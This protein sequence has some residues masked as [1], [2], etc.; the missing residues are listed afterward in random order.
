MQRRNTVKSRAVRR[1]TPR[2]INVH[3]D[4]AAW[5]DTA[6]HVL[7]KRGIDGVRIEVLAKQ[8]EVTKGS[9]YWHFK[10]RAALLEEMLQE[11]RRRATLGIIE[12]L[13]R[14]DEAPLKRM[15]RL[16]RLQF[17]AKQAEFGADVELSVRLWGRHDASAA[18]VLR[19]I[20]ELRLRYISK[21]MVGIGKTESEARARAVLIYSYMRVSRSLPELVEDRTLSD[22]CEDLLVGPS[23]A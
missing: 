6:L 12:R 19:E 11:W 13:E 21:L 9:F 17:D 3:L 18:S 7:A 15:L 14:T 2:D 23:G 1:R 10:D 22:A 16:L 4:R 20:D 5:I 8:L